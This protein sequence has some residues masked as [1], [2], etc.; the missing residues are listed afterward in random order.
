[1]KVTGTMIR[2]KVTVFIHT[3]MEL[4]IRVTGKKINSMGKVKRHGQTVPCM[5]VITSMAR[6]MVEEHSNGQMDLSI[7]DSSSITTSKV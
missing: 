5:K 2:Q 6:S 7:P 1:M 4:S 3:W